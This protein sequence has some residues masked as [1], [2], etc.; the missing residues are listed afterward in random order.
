MS[1][2]I[3]VKLNEDCT[4]FVIDVADEDD[5]QKK[6]GTRIEQLK[7]LKA[8]NVAVGSRIKVKSGSFESFEGFIKSIDD[9]NDIKK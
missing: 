7:A 4:V 5:H 3:S 8:S 1:R 9:K 2:G 6:L